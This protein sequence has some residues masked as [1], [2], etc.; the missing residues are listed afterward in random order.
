[1]K[2]KRPQK[3]ERILPTKWLININLFAAV[4]VLS[5]LCV[6]LVLNFNQSTQK[7]AQNSQTI[8]SVHGHVEGSDYLIIFRD[9][10]SRATVTFSPELPNDTQLITTVIRE[11]LTTVYSIENVNT[12]SPESVTENGS[13]VF[14]VA[15]NNRSYSFLPIRSSDGLIHNMSFGID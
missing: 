13:T 14:R 3:E 5:G 10:T 9:G 4:V 11:I 8:Q 2:T 6:L 12:L 1:M 15:V 7:K